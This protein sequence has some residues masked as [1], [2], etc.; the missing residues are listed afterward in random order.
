MSKALIIAEKSSVAAL[1]ASAL[2]GFTDKGGYFEKSDLIVSQA[3]GHLVGIDYQTEGQWSFGNLP[4]LPDRFDLKVIDKSAH[5]YKRL[6]DLMQR[7][8]VT[9]IINACDAGRE[10]ELIFRL[11]YNKVGNRKPI[12]RMWF[13]SV[14]LKNI[15]QA[16]EDKRP[17]NEYNDLYDAAMSR[18]EADWLIGINATRGMS[19]LHSKRTGQQGGSALSGLGRVQ[20]PTLALVVQRER[21][22]LNFKP[23]DYWEIF[24]EFKTTHG[25]YKS[26]WVNV[27]EKGGESDEGEDNPSN[28]FLDK[29]QAQALVDKC[30]AAAVTSVHDDKKKVKSV[31]PQLFDT[32]AL[33][34]EANKKF[35]F[36]ISKTDGIAQKL[37]EAQLS[38]Y[39]RT[40][41]NVMTKDDE[42]AI[43]EA[44]NGLSGTQYGQYADYVLQN[45]LVSSNLDNTR[46]FNDELVRDHFAIIPTGEK[47]AAG[48]L[49]ADEQKIYDLIVSRF[50]AAFYPDAEYEQTTRTTIVADETF[51][52]SGKV[53]VKN[54]WLDVYG[55]QS[56]EKELLCKLDDDK[57]P[58]VISIDLKQGKTKPPKR[59][60]QGTLVKAM[61][62]AGQFLEEDEKELRKVLKVAGLGRP[63]GRGNIVDGLLSN[64]TSSGGHKEPYLQEVKDDLVPTVKGMDAIAALENE[65]ITVLTS[66][67]MTGEWEQKLLDMEDGKYPRQQFMQEIKALTGDVVSKLK[68]SYEQIPERTIQAHCPRCQGSI[69]VDGRK[70]SCTSCDFSIWAEVAKR[71]ITLPEM[72]TAL[73]DGRTGVLSGFYSESKKRNFSAILVLDKDKGGFNF[74][75]PPAEVKEV[76]SQCP[77]C[78]KTELASDDRVVR[79]KTAGCDFVLWREVASKKLSD[80]QIKELLSKGITKEI[81]GFKS[82]A[83][84]VFSAQLKINP[85]TC[86]AE[87]IFAEKKGVKS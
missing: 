58:D 53:L 7:S 15:K 41:A 87:F 13:S 48:Q 30:K 17:G 28:R 8:D 83:G 63:Q 54:G 14:V 9:G 43:I 51:R 46:I 62:N 16:F 38:T 82:K 56:A 86:K 72:E 34:V 67:K 45:N 5:V 26:R 22:I 23:H 49:T 47:P 73:K 57:L 71:A 25:V 50:I 60:T 61:E 66:P 44:L 1:I 3:Q 36:A 29:A 78:K 10:G 68:N 69:A 64:T 12:Q 55:G 27:K 35:K 75:F 18:S 59:Y 4:I 84:K 21:D 40:D 70:Y 24:G 6:S 37:Y 32:T 33:Q 79:C 77:K 39:P 2:G 19:V 85:E 31:A 81:S 80:A 52:T 65:D 42:P 11:I 76:A 74:E 20:T